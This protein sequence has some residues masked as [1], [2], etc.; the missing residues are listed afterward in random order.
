MVPVSQLWKPVQRTAGPGKRR[1]VFWPFQNG[2]PPP[3][4]GPARRRTV[5]SQAVGTVVAPGGRG[6]GA[7]CSSGRFLPGSHV[8]LVSAVVL[9]RPPPRRARVRVALFL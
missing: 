2:S 4:V 5:R 9:T 6:E 3:A 8:T 1:N 7:S